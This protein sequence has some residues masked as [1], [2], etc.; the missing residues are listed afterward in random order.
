ML[1]FPYPIVTAMITDAMKT[2]AMG[3]LLFVNLL[4]LH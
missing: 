3:K 2:R 4:I 1:R